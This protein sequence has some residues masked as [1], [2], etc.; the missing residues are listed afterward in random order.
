MTTE[1]DAQSLAWLDQEDRRVTEAVRRHGWVVQYV[2]GDKDVPPFAYTIGLF[3]LGHPELIVFGLDYASALRLLNG[4]GSRVRSNSDLSLGEILS[5]EGTDTRVRVDIV[6]NPAQL[7]FAANRYYQRPDE[8]SVPA[9]QLTWDC[10]GAFP[11]E[12]GYTKPQWLQPNP[13]EFRA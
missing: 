9:F 1:P 13:G 11:G 10:E 7:L 4:L 8:A 3:G 6:P 12:S 2:G 5:L